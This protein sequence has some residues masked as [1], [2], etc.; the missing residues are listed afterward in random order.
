ML[1]RFNDNNIWEVIGNEN[2]VTCYKRQYGKF[3]PKVNIDFEIDENV[4]VP[5]QEGV[6]MKKTFNYADWKTFFGEERL[7]RIAD[8]SSTEQYALPLIYYCKYVLGFNDDGMMQRVSS[9]RYIFER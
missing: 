3:T 1:I 5:E 4:M 6:D 2:S 9:T 8:N 7:K